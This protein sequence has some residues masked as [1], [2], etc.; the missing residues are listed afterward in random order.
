MYPTIFTV[1]LP[2]F[3]LPL[4]FPR[5]IH[6]TKAERRHML[7]AKELKVTYGITLEAAM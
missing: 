4:S 1:V 5:K 2:E 3:F 7:L 6:G